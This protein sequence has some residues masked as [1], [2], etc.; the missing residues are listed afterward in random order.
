[1]NETEALKLFH[2]FEEIAEPSFQEFNTTKLLSEILKKNEIKDFREFETGIFGTLDFNKKKTI[3]VR[4]DIDA[5]PVNPQKTVFKHLCGHHL[6]LT[7][8]LVALCQIV[9]ENKNPGSNI[10]FIFQPAEESV[11]GARFIIEKGAMDGVDEVYGIHVDPE[12]SVGTF[13]VKEGE[14]MAGARHIK[15]V[16]FGKGTHAAYPHMG[17]DLIVAASDFVIKCQTIISRKINPVEKAVL[18]FG[19]FSGG[20]IGNV[21][22]DRVELEGTFR[23]FNNFVMEEVINEL[24]KL[25]QSI[26]I[27]Y[28]IK[29]EIDISKGTPPLINKVDL[30]PK[31]LKIM[32]KSSLKFVRDNRISM[33][34]EDFAYYLEKAPGLFIRL[35]MKISDNIV[36]LHNPEFKVDDSVLPY[37][38]DFWKHLILNA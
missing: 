15:I 12:L 37:A 24:N 10:R 31:L 16:F 2:R 20:A 6:H 34:G 11:E 29:Y 13:S 21:L 35:G 38:I 32:E 33:G 18:S 22:P 3:A 36:A 23:Y 17:T 9:N 25:L 30:I 14:L 28:D 26:S 8:L 1:M 4:A 19:K 5:L 7:S 27:Y